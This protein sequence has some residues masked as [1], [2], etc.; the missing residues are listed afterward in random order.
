MSSRAYNPEISQKAIDVIDHHIVLCALRVPILLHIALHDIPM[1]VLRVLACVANTYALCPY[2]HQH[3]NP[4]FF[5]ASGNMA[6]TKNAVEISIP[7]TR[8][9]S[10]FNAPERVEKRLSIP[11]IRRT[12]HRFF[13]SAASPVN[14]A[15]RYKAPTQVLMLTKNGDHS[16]F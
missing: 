15:L 3:Q 4:F 11:M 14:P 5:S 1:C 8:K 13:A 7:L 2:S 10:N 16:V 6:Y 12:K 9:N